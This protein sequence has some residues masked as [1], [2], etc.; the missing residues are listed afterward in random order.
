[1]RIRRRRMTPFARFNLRL[2][3]ANVCLLGAMV[4]RPS[5]S[6]DSPSPPSALPVVSPPFAAGG[7]GGGLAGAGRVGLGSGGGGG[8]GGA[9]EPAVGGGGGMT[10]PVRV[11][12]LALSSSAAAAAAAAAVPPLPLPASADASPPPL[13]LFGGFL[14]PLPVVLLLRLLKL[15][16]SSS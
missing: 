10:L 8:G 4:G 16:R 15:S 1:M 2:S 3:G 9:G 14:I 13:V 5:P 6:G 12:A 7:D 11:L